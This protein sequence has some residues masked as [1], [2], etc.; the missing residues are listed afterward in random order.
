MNTTRINEDQNNIMF[1]DDSSSAEDIKK[2]FK[3]LATK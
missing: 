3:K 1:I 2:R